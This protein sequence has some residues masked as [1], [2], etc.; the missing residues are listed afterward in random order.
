MWVCT[1]LVPAK[2]LPAPEQAFEFTKEVSKED[3]KQFIVGLI[4][5]AKKDIFTTQLTERFLSREVIKNPN[6][7]QALGGEQAKVR[8]TTTYLAY[9]EDILKEY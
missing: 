1:A 2:P 4:A 8:E 6:L 9:L 5:A 7:Q 3:Q